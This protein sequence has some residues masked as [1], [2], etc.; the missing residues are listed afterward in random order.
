MIVIVFHNS[1]KVDKFIVRNSFEQQRPISSVEKKAATFASTHLTL[2]RIY[3]S[4]SQRPKHVFRADRFQVFCCWITIE[5]SDKMEYFRSEIVEFIRYFLSLIRWYLLQF[6]SK[7]TLKFVFC[8]LVNL[9][10]HDWIT[11]LSD[12][13]EHVQ[14]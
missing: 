8:Q 5:I 10:M 7:L 2:K 1:L 14:Y 11:T 12:T 3:S 9:F 6:I 13:K 4:H